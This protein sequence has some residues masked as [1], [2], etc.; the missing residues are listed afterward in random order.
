MKNLIDNKATIILAVAMAFSLQAYGLNSKDESKK[1][2]KKV[3]LQTQEIIIEPTDFQAINALM[4]IIGSA[5]AQGHKKGLCTQHETN[6]AAHALKASQLMPKKATLRG[7]LLEFTEDEHLKYMWTA[8]GGI[9]LLEWSTPTK[10]RSKDYNTSIFEAITKHASLHLQYQRINKLVEH[11]KNK[12]GKTIQTYANHDRKY[13]AVAKVSGLKVTEVDMRPQGW[14]TDKEEALSYAGAMQKAWQ[15]VQQRHRSQT[16]TT[17]A[18]KDFGIDL[19]RAL[20]TTG[21]Q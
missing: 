5:I 2:T 20:S 7:V 9:N 12:N 8:C 3:A 19:N 13:Y 6:F 1:A 18:L 21:K 4:S 10:E 16:E 15:D 14:F 11:K 17:D